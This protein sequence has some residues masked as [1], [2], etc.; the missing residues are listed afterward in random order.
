MSSR[1]TTSPSPLQEELSNFAEAEIYNQAM[2]RVIN[3]SA[4]DES[5]CPDEAAQRTA[6]YDKKMWTAALPKRQMAVNAYNLAIAFDARCS[7]RIRASAHP[8]CSF[9]R[10]PH[11]GGRRGVR[12]WLTRSCGIEAGHLAFDPMPKTSNVH[13]AELT[14]RIGA[15][16]KRLQPVG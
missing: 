16:G 15:A 9:D 6:L 2:P 11:Y 12:D 5:R 13:R 7:A 3:Q 8:A 14:A 10:H 1:G 4:C